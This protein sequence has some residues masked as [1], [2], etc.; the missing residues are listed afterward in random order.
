MELTIVIGY[1]NREAIRVKRCLDSLNNQSWKKFTVIFVDYG[2]FPEISIEIEKV[3]NQYPFC[4]YVYN[5]TRGMVWNRA[6]AL[7]SGIRLS[8][9][10]YVMTT[11]IDFIFSENFIKRMMENVSI[12]NK[13]HSKCFYLP[14][15]FNEWDGLNNSPTNFKRGDESGLGGVMLVAKKWFDEINGFDEFY[16]YWGLEDRDINERLLHLG[17]N[18]IWI[19][20]EQNPVYHQHHPFENLKNKN[21][22]PVGW[23]TEMEFH[24]HELKSQLVRNKNGCGKL[25]KKENRPAL[26]YFESNKN[27]LTTI[28]VPKSDN[29]FQKR[30]FIDNL[31]SSLKKLKKGDGIIMSFDNSVLKKINPIQNLILSFSKFLFE[32]FKIRYE[33]AI[34]KETNPQKYFIPEIDVKNSV[35]KLIIN[36]DLITDYYMEEK[37]G[38]HSY[39]L[40]KA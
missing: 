8:E 11:D 35:W 4:Q 38:M 3:V 33:F 30:V 19:E 16:R 40:V 20:A 1:R 22:M 9:S 34:N 37:D 6:H 10:E 17:L 27:G 39:I 21:Y 15:N 36:Y 5:E 13:I 24:F 7:N 18:N 14:E 12:D 23:W 25:L 26:Q 32:K 29:V 28:E 2:S 31:F